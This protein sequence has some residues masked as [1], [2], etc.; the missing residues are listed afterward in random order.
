MD[1]AHE[2]ESFHDELLAV[3]RKLR[4]QSAR[5]WESKPLLAKT[6]E[7]IRD[8]LERLLSAK[9]TAERVA[10]ARAVWFDSLRN[11]DS[12]TLEE[13]FDIEADLRVSLPGLLGDDYT[14]MCLQREQQRLARPQDQTDPDRR[15]TD[16]FP[17]KVLTDLLAGFDKKEPWPREPAIERL[18]ELYKQSRHDL[19]RHR[20]HAAQAGRYLGRLSPLLAGLLVVVAALL[21]GIDAFDRPAPAGRRWAELFGFG[22]VMLVGAVGGLLGLM[23]RFRDSHGRIRELLLDNNVR[24]VQPLLGAAMALA[25][26]LVV[27]SGLITIAGWAIGAGELAPLAALGFVAGFSEPFFFGVVGRIADA[28]SPGQSQNSK[29]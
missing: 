21:G 2:D 7:H 10:V 14:R 3:V 23:F 29:R 28:V 15:W 9:F 4:D 22:V 16:L 11:L 1:T 25:V 26:V 24:W 17:E 6:L 19:R 18:A 5:E 20:A 27:K 12:L 13:A 8:Y